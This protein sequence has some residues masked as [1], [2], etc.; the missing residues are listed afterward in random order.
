VEAVSRE[1]QAAGAEAVALTVDVRSEED[2]QGMVE[3]AIARFGSIDVL[4]TSAGVIDLS[5]LVE[6]PLRRWEEILTINLTGTF[7][8]V[9]E[10]LVGMVQKGWGR[11]VCISSIAGKTASRFNAA[12]SASKHGVLGLV[13]SVALEVAADGVTVNAICPGF[14]DTPMARSIRP[15]EADLIGVDEKILLR[16]RVR[17][18]PVG[19]YLKPEE[20]APLALFLASDGAAGITGQAI[21]IDGGFFPA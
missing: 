5:P 20:I 21:G 9:R 19:R 3:K 7:L 15:V 13:R 10:G 18:I 6:L 11:I 17:Q 8:C 1:C 4:V 2:V 14:V 16:E 12:Y